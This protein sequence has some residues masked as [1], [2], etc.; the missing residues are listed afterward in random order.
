MFATATATRDTDWVRGNESKL[1]R[2]KY[3]SQIHNE[4]HSVVSAKEGKGKGRVNSNSESEGASG[5]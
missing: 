4:S 2:H 1:W 5:A 3:N